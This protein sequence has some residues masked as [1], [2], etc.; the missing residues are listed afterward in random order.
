MQLFLFSLILP[1]QPLTHANRLLLLPPRGLPCQVEEAS[2]GG[3]LV[4]LLLL[5]CYIA[6][7]MKGAR[8]TSCKS[9]KDRTSVFQTLEVARLAQRFKLL[10]P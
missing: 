4:E 5:S 1:P 6:R 3:K 2:D 9:A 10:S 8:T 7:W